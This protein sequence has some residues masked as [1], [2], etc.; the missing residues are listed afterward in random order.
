MERRMTSRYRGSK[1]LDHNNGSL[2]NEISKKAVGLDRQIN[3]SART[4]R[5]LVHF[6]SAIAALYGTGENNTKIYLS[7]SD[8]ENKR[9]S[10]LNIWQINWTW[11]RSVKFENSANLSNFFGFVVIQKFCYDGNLT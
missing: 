10:P 11:I 5:F 7:K 9:I 1:I 6:F 4:S 8:T 3:N 2:I